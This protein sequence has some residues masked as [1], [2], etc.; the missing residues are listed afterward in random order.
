MKKKLLSVLLCAALAST[1]MMS[2][3]ALADDPV[4]V[5]DLEIPEA[6]GFLMGY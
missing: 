6:G 1:A 5:E 2:F 4:P 3:T